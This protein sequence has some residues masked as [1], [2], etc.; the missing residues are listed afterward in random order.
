M[1]GA[2]FISVALDKLFVTKPLL[3]SVVERKEGQLSFGEKCL[4]DI[5]VLHNLELE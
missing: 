1:S 3:N 4:K 2:I 5:Y